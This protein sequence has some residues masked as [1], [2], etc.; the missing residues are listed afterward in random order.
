MREL[1]FRVWDK[2]FSHF[3]NEGVGMDIKRIAFNFYESLF[4]DN[5]RF[6]FHQYI[7]IKDST[8]KEIYEGDIVENT[9]CYEEYCS[10]AVVAMSVY[11]QLQWALFR[12]IDNPEIDYT[13][14]Q[15]TFNGV[16]L[17]E[18]LPI[19]YSSYGYKVIGNIYENIDIF[20]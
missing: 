19:V 7:G 10:P 4:E 18:E 15:Q 11:E 12:K 5:E 2:Q 17:Y 16:K 6:E 13:P 1:K 8:G 3:W 20:K 14:I 9:V